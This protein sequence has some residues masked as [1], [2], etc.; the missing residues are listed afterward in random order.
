MIGRCQ[1]ADVPCRQEASG[2]KRLSCCGTM[3]LADMMRMPVASLAADTAHLYLW[4]P[5]CTSAGELRVMGVRGFQYKNVW[6]RAC[7]GCQDGDRTW[8]R[9]YNEGRPI[10]SPNGQTHSACVSNW[11]AN[12]LH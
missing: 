11:P 7:F 4:V 12:R 5:K 8:W 9:E 1:A 3:K 2:H 10:K 6:R